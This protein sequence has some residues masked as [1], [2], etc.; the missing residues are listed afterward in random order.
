MLR[1]S[2]TA[3]ILPPCNEKIA[4]RMFS[5]ATLTRSGWFKQYSVAFF[6]LAAKSPYTSCHMASLIERLL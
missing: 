1:P 2:E 3:R 4:I 6:A 5:V